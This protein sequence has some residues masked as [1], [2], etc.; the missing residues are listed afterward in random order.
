VSALETVRLKHGLGEQ[1]STTHGTSRVYPQLNPQLTKQVG[2]RATLCT[3][4]VERLRFGKS[5]R[6]KPVGTVSVVASP[7][8]PAV[9]F[10]GPVFQA[11][12]LTEYQQ[13]VPADPYLPEPLLSKVCT[14]VA[15]LPHPVKALCRALV[16]D[17]TGRAQGVVCAHAQTWWRRRRDDGAHSAGTRPRTPKPASRRRVCHACP[18]PAPALVTARCGSVAGSS[19]THCSTAGGLAVITGRGVWPCIHAT[20]RPASPEGWAQTAKPASTGPNGTCRGTWAGVVGRP[21]PEAR[22][23]PGAGIALHNQHA[24]RRH[25]GEWQRRRALGAVPG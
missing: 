9:T 5:I 13:R 25:R 7:H 22:H 20:V 1:S 17:C 24:A 21:I 16:W 3:S 8:N 4:Y 15:L 11:R 6:S 23:A 12:S 18:V 2:T 19:S 14:A 10:G